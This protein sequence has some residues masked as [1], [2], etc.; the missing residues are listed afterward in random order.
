MRVNMLTLPFG[1]E[2]LALK[3]ESADDGLTRF[4]RLAESGIARTDFYV[5][6][7]KQAS[8]EATYAT[9]YATNA[10]ERIP[11]L[12]A[13]RFGDIGTPTK[14]QL[15]DTLPSGFQYDYKSISWRGTP[16]YPDGI[17]SPVLTIDFPQRA[18]NSSDTIH[19]AIVTDSMAIGKQV[20]SRGKLL[21]AYPRSRDA[22]FAIA[23]A[24]NSVAP[25]VSDPV[26]IA[27]PKPHE[28][29]KDT[30][31]VVVQPAQQDTVVKQAAP[32]ELPKRL[33]AKK[34]RVELKQ[35]AQVDSTRFDSVKAPPID[36]AKVVEQP[37][38]ETTK[39]QK[40]SRV[41][42]LLGYD[43]GKRFYEQTELFVRAGGLIASG[44][45]L[46]LLLL[47]L[48]KRRKRKEEK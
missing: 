34:R 9:M 21:L 16:L 6:R 3:S 44:V 19:L 27:E 43:E 46:Y 29:P 18:E 32:V 1:A 41:A 17:A 22:S 40:R 10:G 8:A 14:I 39:R 11:A 28:E 2:V 33:V 23:Q 12:Y 13:I 37:V 4:V 31:A 26:V 35:L 30:A 5:R 48:W 36:S 45:V 20:A 47:L 7:P 38:V 25:P 15:A 42:E 24:Y